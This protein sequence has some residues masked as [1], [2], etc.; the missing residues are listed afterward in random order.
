MRGNASLKREAFLIDA[1]TLEHIKASHDAPL[2]LF[3]VMGTASCH[4]PTY[5]IKRNCV[6]ART[7]FFWKSR[8]FFPW[9]RQ[10]QW[11]RK[12]NQVTPPPLPPLRRNERRGIW[13]GDKSNPTP[14]PPPPPPP[15]FRKFSDRQTGKG[16]EGGR[17]PISP[18]PPLQL[19]GTFF[20]PSS[21][22]GRVVSIPFCPTLNR[23]L[24]LSA[25]TVC[26]GAGK[27]GGASINPAN[28]KRCTDVF[29]FF[30]PPPHSVL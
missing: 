5:S 20:L 18:D 29:F 19:E 23:N 9:R 21:Q 6:A 24:T 15:L 8:H 26:K 17:P 11:G 22:G 28:L 4:V 25:A 7:F 14:P 2:P 16:R 1:G 13:R 12:N 10:Q 27:K 3:N 30:P